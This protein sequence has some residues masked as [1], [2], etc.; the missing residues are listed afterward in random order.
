VRLRIHSLGQIFSFLA[1]A[2]WQAVPIGDMDRE[3]LLK[4]PEK[5]LCPRR[6]LISTLQRSD[7][8]ALTSK[9]ALPPLNAQ[10]R[11]QGVASM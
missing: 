11:P 4:N 10:L 2:F 9:A 7:G 3:S 6:V 1:P 8:L 5:S